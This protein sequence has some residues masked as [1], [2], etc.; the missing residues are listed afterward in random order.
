MSDY[1]DENT[2]LYIKNTFY[3][4]MSESYK[5]FLKYLEPGDSILDAGCGPGRDSLYFLK[6][7]FKVSAFDNSQS[8]VDFASAK[9]GIKVDKNNFLDISYEN[10][11]N[12]V[13]ASASLLHVSRKDL[14]VA[15]K[16]LYSALKVDGLFFCSFKC[17]SQDFKSGN[18]IFTCFNEVSFNKFI[19]DLPFFSIL[20]L[21]ISQDKR[22][23]RDDE[24]WV[25]VI[26]KKNSSL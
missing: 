1:Y 18:R 16:N 5:I 25:N 22:E 13:W 24:L 3:C 8:M 7:D 9:T 17:R 6:E 21:Y 14:P 4:D 20:E 11:F 15:F 26:L 23:N 12:A 10:Q 19:K 2:E